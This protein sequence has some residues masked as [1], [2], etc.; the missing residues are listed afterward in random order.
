MNQK[1]LSGLAVALLV[2]TLGVAPSGYADPAE[3]VDE[4]GVTNE[5]SRVSAA[6]AT[7]NSA[8]IAHQPGE[9][10]SKPAQSQAVAP[11]GSSSSISS[12][13]PSSSG[14]VPDP[15]PDAEQD[16]AVEPKVSSQVQPTSSVDASTQTA[17]ST[18]PQPSEAIKVG[19][20]QSPAASRTDAIATLESHAIRGRQA[21]TLY[22]RNIPVLTFLGAS[23][24]A[25]A[26][27]SANASSPASA[28]PSAEVKIA[29]VQPVSL[30]AAAL[31]SLP[32]EQ[33]PDQLI[34][35]ETSVADARDPVWRAT[36][37]AARLNQLY[38]DSIDASEIKISWDSDR[39]K[40][41]VKA[42]EVEVIAFDADTVLPDT[43]TG[44]AGDLLQATNR[45]RRQMGNASPLSS[46][47]GDPN[48]FNQ[49]SLGP[50]SLRVSGYASWYGPGFEGAYSASGER[51][52]AEALTA[53][54]PSLPFGTQIRVTNMDNGESVVVRVND[55]GP[56]A[57]GRVIDLSAGAARV[58]GLIQAGV[59]P[60]S[61]EV[62]GAAR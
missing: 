27:S 49:V 56:Y 62:L 5:N 15:A 8:L 46:I 48:G 28:Q 55:R 30:Q 34:L 25:A 38:R 22:V 11:D 24:D 43:V 13:N 54:H 59:A 2:S 23:A 20:H 37:T 45:I 47:E 32:T 53:A 10:A 51:F 42:S 58:I 57:H 16:G 6:E 33:R 44:N 14:L 29:H 18:A 4:S 31:Q 1:L 9:A 35:P 41:V 26:S 7:P 19:A 60:V 40:Y 36:T 61:L 17:S 12:T 52:N 50:I 21:A 3:A 39:R